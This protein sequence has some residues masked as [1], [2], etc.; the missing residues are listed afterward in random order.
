MNHGFIF[1]CFHRYYSLDFSRQIDRYY[2]LDFSRQIDISQTGVGHR[3]GLVSLTYARCVDFSTALGH[4][5][6]FARKLASNEVICG[7]RFSRA[8]FV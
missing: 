6:H 4:S 2:S 8:Y 5:F 7:K 3:V 1:F